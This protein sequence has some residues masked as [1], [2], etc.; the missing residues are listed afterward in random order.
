MYVCMFVCGDKKK[1]NHLRN[2]YGNK[3]PSSIIH[4]SFFFLSLF[5]LFVYPFH[6]ENPIPL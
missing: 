2:C 6:P 4:V 5:F 3:Q 1:E